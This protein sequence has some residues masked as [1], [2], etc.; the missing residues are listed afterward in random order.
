MSE[1]PNKTNF[2][3]TLNWM[4]MLKPLKR[5][6]PWVMQALALIICDL[7]K[8]KYWTASFQLRARA[9]AWHSWVRTPHVWQMKN[10]M[11][12]VFQHRSWVG[13]LQFC[14]SWP[15][16]DLLLWP[17]STAPLVQ[18]HCLW[19]LSSRTASLSS[20]A[21][22]DQIWKWSVEMCLYALWKKTKSY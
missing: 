21:A 1:C 20:L 15:F 9:R 7:T 12:S 14:L 13:F 18:S 17:L 3:C 16:L 11:V 2:W 19:S 8:F 4:S 10:C 6:Q 22:K 5:V